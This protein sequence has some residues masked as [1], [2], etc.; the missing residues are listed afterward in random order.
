MH[1]ERGLVC[2]GDGLVRLDKDH[3]FGDAGDDLLQLGSIRVFRQN[4]SS[5]V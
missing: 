1:G 2:I 4:S 3:A 5:P